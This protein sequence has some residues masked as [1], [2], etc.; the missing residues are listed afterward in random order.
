MEAACGIVVA[1]D[2]FVAV[3]VALSLLNELHHV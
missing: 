1:L 2:P 3:R